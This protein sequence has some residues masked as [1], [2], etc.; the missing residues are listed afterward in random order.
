MTSE[1]WVDVLEV[2]QDNLEVYLEEVK[3]TGYTTVG[4]EQ[5]A[6][7]TKLHNYTFPKKCVLVLGNEKEGIP[8]RIFPF[9]DVC[10]EIPQFGL[11]RSLNVHVAGAITIWE[12]VK[13]N[14]RTSAIV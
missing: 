8:S 6:E 9:L 3:K 7:S 1:Y 12:Y 2:K 10:L 11:L 13:Q 4:L 14:S 5:T